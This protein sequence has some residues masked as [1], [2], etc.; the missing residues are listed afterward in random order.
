[1]TVHAHRGF[2]KQAKSSHAENPL[3][4]RDDSIP[5]RDRLLYYTVV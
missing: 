2:T 1:L 3:V 4:I 5:R